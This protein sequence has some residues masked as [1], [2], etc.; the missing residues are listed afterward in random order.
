[1]MQ[2]PDYEV[3]IVTRG[4]GPLGPSLAGLV[5][6]AQYQPFP[7][8]LVYGFY[9]ED[10]AVTGLLETLR[11]MGC[12]VVLEAQQGDTLGC[13]RQQ[14]AASAYSTV[15]N[16]DDDAALVPAGGFPRLAAASFNHGWAAP[17]VRFVQNFKQSPPQHTEIWERVRWDHPRV[18]AAVAERGDG[19][20]RVYD[21]GHDFVT[22]D[23]GGTCFAVR[24]Q[25]W[26]MVADQLTD[27]HL[28]EDVRLGQ[29]LGRG[30][31]LS[32]VYAYHF[33]NY[34][35]EKWADVDLVRR[36]LRTDPEAF[37]RML[38]QEPPPEE[39]QRP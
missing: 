16:L 6:H 3:C 27:W 34:G 31:T 2:R 37:K 33:G 12:R 22:D 7:L 9:P 20:G 14:Q 10:P 32:G 24:S 17:V 4:G 1:M 35:A 19:W 38:Q 26:R 8:R 18:Q 29:L 13:W 23:L 15:I 25:R 28:G 5:A 39:G 21:L 36:G 11:R 30:V